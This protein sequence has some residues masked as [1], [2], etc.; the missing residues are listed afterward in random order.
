MSNLKSN[1]K[2]LAAGLSVFFAMS[3]QMLETETGS[4][5][6][7]ERFPVKISIRS[8]TKAT[9]A[10]DENRINSLQVF[11]F[12]ENGVL[13]AFSS[14][15]GSV[16]DIECTSGK[17]EFIAV[18][19][20]PDLS[21]IASRSELQSARS[22]L[23]DNAAADFV[24]VGSAVQDIAN[25][26]NKVPMDARRLVARISVGKI[27]NALSAAAYSDTDIVIKSLYLSNVAGDRQYLA[28]DTPSVWLNR[29]GAQ[30]DCPALLHSGSLDCSITNGESHTD[31]H[32]FYCYPNPVVS[33]SEEEIWCPR[34]TRLVIVAEISGN[35][36]YYPVS[37]GNILANHSY[38]IESVK[39][40][41]LGSDSPEFPVE[42]GTVSLTVTV[43]DWEDGT[44][45]TVTI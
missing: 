22:L 8:D 18:A 37:I 19:N 34:F 38:N 27:T 32:Y 24:M 14:G 11:V 5:I 45:T 2:K 40:T 10:Q 3:C 15:S 1:L 21:H 23:S 28:Q 25:A 6:A 13:D 17:K 4:G 16:L 9:S 31:T 35:T 36:Y 26:V 43:L 20:A 39:I 41:R 12:R 44:T 7:E 33:D 29:L 30:S 42:T